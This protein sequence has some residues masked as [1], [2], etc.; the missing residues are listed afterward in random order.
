[1]NDGS[2][3]FIELHRW[4]R[5]LRVLHAILDDRTQKDE[6][7]ESAKRLTNMVLKSEL[8]QPPPDYRTTLRRFPT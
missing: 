8:L 4:R 1:M 6:K 2:E 7:K 3:T 5:F